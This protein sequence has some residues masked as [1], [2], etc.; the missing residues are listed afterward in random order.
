MPRMVL[1]R[2]MTRAW[3]AAMA[4]GWLAICT[5][6]AEVR[7]DARRYI[8][9][10]AKSEVYFSATFPMGNFSG[11]T[12]D[13]EGEFLADPNDLRAGITGALRVKAY[14]MRT[15]DSGRDRD[16]Y[17]ALA[18]DR[19]PEIRFTIERVEASFGS[20]A[21][22]T[23]VLLTIV[24]LMSIRGEERAMTFPGRVRLRDGRLW[25]RGEAE[26]RMS[27]FGIKPPSRFFVSVKDVVLVSFDVTLA[28]E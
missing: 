22:R 27:Q 15:G 1:H 14:S 6:A 20:V 12:S 18:V 28:P 16:M 10:P 17:R 25:V 11:R 24:G 19:F 7:A 9:V 4:L 2:V 8:P 13:I 21:D 3:L 23:D 26:L 5:A